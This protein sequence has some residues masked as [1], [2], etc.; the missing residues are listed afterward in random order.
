MRGRRRLRFASDGPVA[1]LSPV[2]LITLWSIA[3]AAG[4]PATPLGDFARG[5]LEETRGHDGGEWFA[6]AYA[7]DPDAWPLASRI[8]KARFAE[9]D[10]EGA[11]TAYREFA[12]AHP[13]RLAA[14][15]AYADF[16]REST[17]GD[18]FAA[19]LAGDTLEA[20]LGRFPDHPGVLRR[21]F[22][23]YEERG[24]RER[25]LELFES[26]AEAGAALLAAE[27]AGTL[28]PADD[29]TTRARI[30]AIYR[31]GMERR[32]ADPG[33]ARAA[34]EHFRTSGRLD[35]AVEMLGLHAGAAPSSLDLRTRLGVLL[36]AA[37]RGAEGERVLGEVLA[38]DP[39]QAVAHQ[40][41]A[42]YLRK[43][44]RAEEARPHAAELLKIRGGE[45]DDFTTLAAELIGAGRPREARLLLEKGLY[46]HP[47]EPEIAA[48][49]AIAT[50][51]DPET[52]L[53]AARL[54]REAETLSG[55]DGPAARPEFLREFAA[56]LL[57]AGETAAAE[58]R[59]RTAIKLYPPEE[60]AGTAAAL[61]ALA[62]IWQAEGRNAAA[63]RSLLRRADALDPP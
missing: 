32:P 59:L 20:A 18:G 22:R 43:E 39:R 2:R 24:L 35:E 58:D 8:A 4:M 1:T 49:L 11:S 53:A 9:G 23:T 44:G 36:F 7:E 40:A 27:M 15:L 56:C 42:K 52:A 16:L 51:R 30:D 47:D 13:E 21:L 17:P 6:R 62:A 10:I 38:I 45:P 50:R 28:F 33:L 12:L 3:L 29:D 5:V 37:G 57:E 55:T 61:R 54:F 46:D 14:Q 48:A 34:S 26:Q 60:K 31:R 41:L 25:S 19:K 63:A